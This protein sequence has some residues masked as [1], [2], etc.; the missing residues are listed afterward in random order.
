MS[1][2]AY[3]QDL[4]NI[5]A[6]LYVNMYT[7]TFNANTISYIQKNKRQVITMQGYDAG[8]LHYNPAL[9]WQGVHN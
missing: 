9:C 5:L 7:C 1:Q 2:E 4:Y 6:F 8:S 3:V